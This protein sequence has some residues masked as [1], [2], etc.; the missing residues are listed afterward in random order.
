MIWS[1][2]SAS[3]SWGWRDH[4]SCSGVQQPHDT[5]T[6]R[7]VTSLTL[8]ADILIQSSLSGILIKCDVFLFVQQIWVKL[9]CGAKLECH[10][11]R[12]T[13]HITLNLIQLWNNTNLW[14]SY[15]QMNSFTRKGTRFLTRRSSAT[16]VSHH[17]HLIY[18][19]DTTVCDWKFDVLVMLQKRWPKVSLMEKWFWIKTDTNLDGKFKLHVHFLAFWGKQQQLLYIFYH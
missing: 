10:G 19:S 2:V 11:E 14:R 12:I 18:C 17:L 15:P 1:H 8:T 13:P 6:P 7:H 4:P 9:L 5:Q 16:L 3:G